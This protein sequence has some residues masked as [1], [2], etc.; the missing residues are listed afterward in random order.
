MNIRPDQNVLVFLKGSTHQ[1]IEWSYT[2]INEPR[3]RIWYFTSSDGKFNK[4][5]LAEI[6]RNDPYKKLS[7]ALEFD[8]QPPATL[9]LNNV[10]NSYN[11]TY[12]FELAPGGLGSDVF[13]FITGK[14]R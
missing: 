5:P 1:K 9:I 3:L 13:V 12:R 8:I 2:G 11:G 14:F 10:N 4:E 7:N 6:D